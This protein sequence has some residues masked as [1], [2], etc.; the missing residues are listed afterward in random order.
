MYEEALQNPR[1]RARV[2]RIF[3]D[4]AVRLRQADL[5]EGSIQALL[6]Y[7]DGRGKPN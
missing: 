7:L 2:R 4:A 5:Y 6:S 3:E 1:L